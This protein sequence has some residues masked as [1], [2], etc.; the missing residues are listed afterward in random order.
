MFVSVQTSAF[1]DV[2]RIFKSYLIVAFSG[3]I[4]DFLRF[5]LYI[6]FFNLDPK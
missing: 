6:L 4:F 3:M 2:C 5:V 1:P